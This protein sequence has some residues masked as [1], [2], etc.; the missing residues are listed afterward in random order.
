MGRRTLE[1]VKKEYTIYK[2]L[3]EKLAKL[4]DPQK[5]EKSEEL[6]SVQVMVNQLMSRAKSIENSVKESEKE[7]P[8]FDEIR[9][10]YAELETTDLYFGRMSGEDR[11]KYE[12]IFEETKDSS[13]LKNPAWH[14]AYSAFMVTRSLDVTKEADEYHQKAAEIAKVK[15]TKLSPL[16]KE[17][18]KKIKGFLEKYPN[19]DIKAFMETFEA[20]QADLKQLENEQDGMRELYYIAQEKVDA[21]QKKIDEKNRTISGL[22]ENKRMREALAG[23]I[24]TVE[25]NKESL[26]TIAKNYYWAKDE[27]DTIE[28][29]ISRG[30]GK[31]YTSKADFHN[32]TVRMFDRISANQ[33]PKFE[34]RIKI[35]KSI[36]DIDKLQNYIKYTLTTQ[37]E[38]AN[39]PHL[40]RLTPLAL[41]ERTQLG[42][43]WNA[44]VEGNDRFKDV[45]F[46][47]V[48]DISMEQFNEWLEEHK[49][50]LQKEGDG[51]YNTLSADEQKTFDV[52]QKRYTDAE[53][54]L[55]KVIGDLEKP[56][57]EL[58]NARQKMSEPK[59]VYEDTMKEIQKP[60]GKSRIY[61]DLTLIRNTKRDIS[62]FKNLLQNLDNKIEKG[63][64][65]A[66]VLQEEVKNLEGELDAF[67]K[68]DGAVIEKYINNY[69]Q[70]MKIYSSMIDKEG[71]RNDLKAIGKHVRAYAKER[72]SVKE[73]PR[74]N[75]ADVI[76]GIQ[77]V[78]KKLYDIKDARR[79][80]H[81]NSKE[82]ERMEK[83]MDIVQKWPKEN[84]NEPSEFATMKDALDHL[85][86][87]TAAYLEAKYA[88]RRPIP[89]VMRTHRIEYAKSILLI[90]TELGNTLTEDLNLNAKVYA[91]KNVQNE[92]KENEKATFDKDFKLD[93]IQFEKVP[94]DVELTMR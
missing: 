17:V 45:T 90:A 52:V 69:Q 36:A 48:E 91:D 88:Q 20:Q 5:L 83:A 85:K 57:Q 41:K 76:K 58:Y 77:H 62:V 87:Q 78:V 56:Y 43:Y 50:A 1:S 35:S 7:K 47:T 42:D 28:T 89:T 9:K 25:Q 16:K 15:A 19:F 38:L 81:K 4:C 54:G 26:D 60:F 10:H 79:G 70:Q 71:V 32:E 18:N 22:E 6:R 55:L 46:E 11:Q 33:S 65:D 31:D 53:K 75:E 68:G 21:Y 14:A 64:K 39:I 51:I 94:D 86:Q 63:E 93:E 12:K 34:E 49:E 30:I 80:S 2:G 29:K 72:D 61:K 59:K 3:Y 67:K 82:F 40:K 8:D 37:P 23:Y 24:E 66:V 92:I 73:L 84:G 27:C 44:M 74:G 13:L